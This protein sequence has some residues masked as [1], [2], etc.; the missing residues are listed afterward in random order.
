MAVFVCL[1]HGSLGAACPCHTP[2]HMPLCRLWPASWRVHGAC[3]QCRTTCIVSAIV[4]LLRATSFSVAWSVEHRVHSRIHSDQVS[5]TAVAPMPVP[6]SI[7]HPQGKGLQSATPAIAQSEGPFAR[8]ARL[9]A[10]AEA[11][12]VA[13]AASTDAIIGNENTSGSVLESEQPS[14]SG[15]SVV[16]EHL[17]FSYPGL[18]TRQRE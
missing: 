3:I 16:V 12:A 1:E 9:R 4:T 5:P 8:A 18:G 7:T 15:A 17:S 10:E 14:T 6:I 13:Q 11:A 2:W